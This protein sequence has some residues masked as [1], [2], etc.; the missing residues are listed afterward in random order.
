MKEKKRKIGT[1]HFGPKVDITDPGYDKDTWCRIND[2]EIRE[3]DYDCLVWERIEKFSLCE[4]EITSRTVSR[5]G[6]Y[7]EGKIPSEEELLYLGEIGVDAGLAGFFSDK[8]DYTE[9]EWHQF[10]A[11]IFPE[12]K[13]WGSAW[14]KDEGFFSC[15]GEGDGS[16]PVVYATDGLGQITA[17]EIRF[18]S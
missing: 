4:K 1:K 16:Y 13:K 5:I 2:V 10:C 15:S 18:L 12:G 14:I 7:L 8:P 6:I 11:S 3:G 17:L 9:A